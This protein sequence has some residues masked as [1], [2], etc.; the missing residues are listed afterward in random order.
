MERLEYT[1]ETRLDTVRV[2]GAEVLATD[3][4]VPPPC[5]QKAKS[6]PNASC[7]PIDTETQAMPTD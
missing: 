6:S 7:G 4:S 3:I 2:T 5:G 1:V